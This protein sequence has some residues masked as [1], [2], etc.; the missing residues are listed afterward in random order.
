MAG[1]YAA[2]IFEWLPELTATRLLAFGTGRDYAS[3]SAFIDGAKGRCK[4]IAFFETSNRG[5]ICGGYLEP[6]WNDAGETRDPSRKSFIF[7]LRNHLGVPPTKFPM[8]SSATRGAFAG[9]GNWVGFGSPDIQLY[10]ADYG[11]NFG[12]H[13]DVVGRGAAI[14]QGDGSGRFRAGSWELWQTL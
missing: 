12:F 4:T 3:I 10:S 11:G 13:Q 8:R 14:F 6:A 5:S 1:Q 9:R 2:S 7:T